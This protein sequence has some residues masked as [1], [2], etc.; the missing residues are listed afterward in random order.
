MLTYVLVLLKSNYFCTHL[1]QETSAVKAELIT[2]VEC[3]TSDQLQD[4][5]IHHM[6]LVRLYEGFKMI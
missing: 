3:V 5:L 1:I 2:V 6:F 4:A